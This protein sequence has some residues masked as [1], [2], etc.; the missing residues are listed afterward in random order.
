M[1]FPRLWKLTKSAVHSVL[2]IIGGFTFFVVL[3]QDY[4]I[5]PVM[6]FELGSE[7]RVQAPPEVQVHRVATSDENEISVWELPAIGPEKKIAIIAHGNGGNV[8]GFF[9]VQLALQQLGYSTYGFDY[10]GIGESSGSISEAGIYLDTEAVWNHVHS[11]E[12]IA[13]SELTIVGISIGSAPAAYLAHSIGPKTLLLIAPFTS[14]LD[15][16]AERPG[17]KYLRRFSRYYFPTAAFTASA[18]VKCL[19]IAYGDA[20]NVIS[21]NSSRKIEK[22]WR[23]THEQTQTPAKIFMIEHPTADHN[24]IFFDAFDQIAT[25]LNACNNTN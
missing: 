21:P 24:S 3:F 22:M 12:Q 15:A 16:I 8:R 13:P 5:F 9:P 10:R 14:M 1:T 17:L 6:L 2:F 11:T 4:L 23:A 20:D 7:R 25:Q 18:A 19:I